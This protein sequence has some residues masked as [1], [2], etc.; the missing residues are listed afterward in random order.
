MQTAI[1][2][3]MLY[4]SIIISFVRSNFTRRTGRK[5]ILGRFKGQ[6]GAVQQTVIDDPCRILRNQNPT[7]IDIAI[8]VVKTATIKSVVTHA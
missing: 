7:R 2:R 6:I 3:Y 1:I 4:E 5:H 8:N